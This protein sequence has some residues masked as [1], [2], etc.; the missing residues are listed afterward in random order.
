LLFDP[1]LTRYSPP[2]NLDRTGRGEAAFAGFEQTSTSTY[3]VWTYNNASTDGCDSYNRSANVDR[4][5][6]LTR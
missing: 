3:D 1:P 4:S 2:I 6:T 5:G